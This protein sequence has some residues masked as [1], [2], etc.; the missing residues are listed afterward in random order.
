M[1]YRL[2][3]IGD[4]RLRELRERCAGLNYH[5]SKADID[6]VCVQLYTESKTYIDMWTDNFYHMSEE[7]RSHA[8]IF[9]LTDPSTDLHAE[10]HVGTHTMFLFIF[11]YYGW[12]KSIALGMVFFIV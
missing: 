9:C 4:D 7:V 2:V 1:A 10:Y 6:G 11:D 8:R 12:V 3:T 5:T